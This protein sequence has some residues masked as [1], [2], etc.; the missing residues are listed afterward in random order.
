MNEMFPWKISDFGIV[1]KKKII[2]FNT[3]QIKLLKIIAKFFF[4]LS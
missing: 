3:I 2:I 1:L 4:L